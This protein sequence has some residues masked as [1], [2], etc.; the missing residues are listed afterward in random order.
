MRIMSW[1]YRRLGNPSTI[2]ELK[3]S[4]RLFKPELVFICETKRRK[5][6]VGTVC[7]KFG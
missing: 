5:G 2:P 7:K 6:F 3:E 1:N 4:L